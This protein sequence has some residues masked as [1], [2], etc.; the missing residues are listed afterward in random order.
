MGTYREKLHKLEQGDLDEVL[1]QFYCNEYNSEQGKDRL[2]QVLRGYGQAFDPEGMRD[3]WVFSSP[4]RTELGGNHTDHQRGHVLCASVDMDIL[5]CAAPNGEDVI[6][7]CSQ[8]YP[9]IVVKLD[10]LNALRE[11]EGTSAG[12]VRGIAARVCELGYAVSGFDACLISDVPAGSGLSSSAAFEVLVGTM[13]NHFSCGGKLTAVE[14]AQIGQY[15]ENHYFGKPCGLMDQMACAVGSIVA[16]DF[17]DPDRPRVERVE[18]D[19]VRSGHALCIVDTGS[20]H[21]DLTGDY[22]D[23][24]REMREAAAFFGREYLSEVTKEQALQSLSEMR[25]VCS[26]RAI[27]RMLHF[28]EE[29]MRA[30]EQAAVLADGD[31]D[32]FLE[33]V[34]RSGL[35]S[36][37]NLQNIWSPASP[38][39]QAVSLALAVGRELLGETGAI[40]VHGGGFAGTIQAFVPDEKLEGFKAG[41]EKVFG[42]GAC[43]VTH[44]RPQGGCVVPV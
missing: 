26:D 3:V 34:N 16:I 8:G 15:A 39:D 33:L 4:G 2:S 30:R 1:A 41:M 11:E 7:L 21:A 5:A 22:A 40:R 43:R 35:S 42:E 29:D 20:C 10:A 44:I 37:L 6:R 31:F 18:F 25:K 14:I 19:F 9:E 24:T 27:L 12:L 32:R 38:G 13:I 17:S 28:F 36:A 23:I